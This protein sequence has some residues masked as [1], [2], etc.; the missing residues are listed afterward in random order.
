[1]ARRY[2]RSRGRSISSSRG[3]MKKLS[4]IAILLLTLPA[5]TL[6]NSQKPVPDQTWK[7]DQSTLTYHMS[8]PMHE[9]DGQSHAA[10]GKGICHAGQCDFLVAAP[11]KSF[12]S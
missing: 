9:M 11:V 1:M 2:L 5:Y 10:L 8:H 7:L 3:T 6:L 12:D 4:L